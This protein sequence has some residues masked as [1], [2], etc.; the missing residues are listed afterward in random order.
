V[1]VIGSEETRS[2]ESGKEMVL[3]S[4]V[5]RIVRIPDHTEFLWIPVY[6][7]R[8]ENRYHRA[9]PEFLLP[10]K[11]YWVTAITDGAND[12]QFLD[13]FSLPSDSSC[14]RWKKLAYELLRRLSEMKH[15][16]LPNSLP[17]SLRSF[18]S[19]AHFDN[20]YIEICVHRFTRKELLWLETCS[21]RL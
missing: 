3:V 13:Q 11:H 16:D 4:H 5:R 14:S 15:S 12:D 1:V 7:S 6:Y 19:S 2:P 17:S 20:V 21:L 8:S 18:T 9:L 10:F